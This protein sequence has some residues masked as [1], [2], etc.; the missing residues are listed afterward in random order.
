MTVNGASSHTRRAVRAAIVSTHSEHGGESGDD[1]YATHAFTVVARSISAGIAGVAGS[2]SDQVRPVV[3][4]RDAFAQSHASGGRHRTGHRERAVRRGRRHDLPQH[5]GRIP[6]SFDIFF[7]TGTPGGIVGLSL[8]PSGPFEDSVIV[9]VD[10]NGQGSGTSPPI[11]V[12]GLKGG[13]TAIT[14]SGAVFPPPPPLPVAVFQ[15]VAAGFQALA[16]PL[17]TNPNAGE[18]HEFAGRLTA[19][20]AVANTVKVSAEVVPQL[21]GVPVTFRA[22][23]VDDPFTDVGPVDPNGLAGDDNRAAVSLDTFSAPTDSAGVATAEFAVSMQP[24]DNYRI[25]A[26]CNAVYLDGV[27]VDGT[28]LKDA[29]GAALPTTRAAE[30]DMLTVWRKV[31]VEV[32]SMGVVTGNSIAGTVLKAKHESPDQAELTVDADLEKNRFENGAIRIGNVERLVLENK[33]KKVTVSGDV[34]DEEVLGQAF[35]LVDDDDFNDNDQVPSPPTVGVVKVH[36]DEGEDVFKS[37]LT[38]ISDSLDNGACDYSAPNV[39]GDAYVC[40]VFDVGD[41]N[42]F[43]PFVANVEQGAEVAASSTS[44]PCRPKRI[45]LSGPYTCWARIRGRRGSITI[46]IRKRRKLGGSMPSMARGRRSTPR[47]SRT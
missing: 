45:R 33:G 39:F 1:P 12:K 7:V 29:D 28:G 46:P 35:T 19:G 32:D 24:G 8:D 14:A 17:D 16:A 40:P 6:H 21:P 31:H 36:G 42:N 22:F 38:L 27:V 2:G 4:A 10:T 34:S 18:A 5:R 26:G 44:M 9:R 13:L 3:A 43:A 25:A 11:Y 37:D 47:S 30:T 41:N 20:G 23:D 15:V